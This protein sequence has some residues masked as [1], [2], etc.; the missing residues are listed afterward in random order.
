TLQ[1]FMPVSV[2]NKYKRD[3]VDPDRAF[4][5]LFEI[6]IAW[7]FYSRGN[8]LKWYE[9]DGKKHPEF[10][11]KTPEF[12][13]NVECKRISDDISRQIKDDDFNLL[14]DKLLPK[15]GKQGYGG[16]IDIIIN[17]RLEGSQINTLVSEIM[18]LI[19]SKNIR[20]VFTISLGQVSLNLNER[21]GKIVNAIENLHTKYAIGVRA[22]VCSSHMNGDNYVDP[23][24]FSIKSKKPDEVLDGIY[25][26]V[27][28]AAKNQLDKSMPGIIV[29]FLEGVYD[30]RE[31]SSNS[32]LQLMTCKLLNKDELSHIARI[33]YC[34]EKH[35]HRLSNNA[36]SYDNQ[37]LFFKNQKCKFED[38]VQARLR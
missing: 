11:V 35:I 3:L 12:N 10:L 19:I 6:R 24:E 22:V 20:G 34:S 9:D 16:N 37:K 36:E 2:Q 7:D 17:G 28:E 8:E 4:D 32:G 31:L 38:G 14:I 15:I 30:L 27:Y 13:F 5:Y 26:K 29:C 25:D 1:K 21:S 18:Q 23:I 33:E